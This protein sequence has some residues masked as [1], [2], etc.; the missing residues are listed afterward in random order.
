MQAV[1]Q[2]SILVPELPAPTVPEPWPAAKTVVP[3]PS[4]AQNPMTTC[5]HPDARL[6]LRPVR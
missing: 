2:I 3:E 6:V 1:K 4:V 5:R